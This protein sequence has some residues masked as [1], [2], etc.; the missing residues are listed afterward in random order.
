MKK[1]D[2]KNKIS[3]L[4]IEILEL[5]DKIS[6]LNIEINKLNIEL[7]ELDNEM[8]QSK[9]LIH[10]ETESQKQRIIANIKEKEIELQ[11]KNNILINRKDRKSGS[12]GMPRPISYAV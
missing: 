10:K 12:A 4:N 3:E 2:I 7:R 1:N 9:K 5:D 11:Q 6:E 8:D